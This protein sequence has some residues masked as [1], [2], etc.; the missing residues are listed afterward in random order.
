MKRGT[1]EHPKVGHL[2]SLLNIPRYG[3][4]G[5]L[6]C[7]WHFT[8]R[9][10]PQGDIGKHSDKTI[11][12]AVYWEK[13]PG[14]IR[15]PA[16]FLPSSGRVTSELW[17]SSSLV[18]AEFLDRS[19]KYRLIVHDWWEHADE[20]VRKFLSRHS[21]DFVRT[22]SSLPEPLP[23]PEPLPEPKYS[24]SKTVEV[25]GKDSKASAITQA[26]VV[27]HFLNEQA[28]RCYRETDQNF[29][30]ICGR[31]AEVNWDVEGVKQMI[32]RQVG[33]WKGDP[34]MEEYLRPETLFGK[35]KFGSYFDNRNLPI[36]TNGQPEKNQIRENI[37]VKSL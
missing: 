26:R 37:T 20:A 1:P 36:T 25:E 14:S 13:R 11:A 35:Q 16:E 19:L 5:I 34:K 29:K 9:Y 17:L 12:A 27:I 23:V 18:R 32:V 10:A 7:L 33:K 3:A 21:L 2:A 22:E 30:L 4:V 6:E 15:V 24:I 8:A 31:L 28:G